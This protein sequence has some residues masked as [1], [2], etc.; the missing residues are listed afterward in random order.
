M[1][2]LSSGVNDRGT[3]GVNGS[4][5]ISVEEVKSSLDLVDLLDGAVVAGEVLCVETHFGCDG[6]IKIDLINK[7]YLFFKTLNQIIY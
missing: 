6:Y 1:E 5:E 4:S 3:S 2:T 7:N